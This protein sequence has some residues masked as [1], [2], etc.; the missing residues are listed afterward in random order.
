LNEKNREFP[1]FSQAECLIAWRQGRN[2]TGVDG[3]AGRSSSL[4]SGIY[5]ATSLIGC[6]TPDHAAVPWETWHRILAP[7]AK[8]DP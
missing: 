6:C 3:F 1:G 8:L 2:R 4:E 7:N 5:C